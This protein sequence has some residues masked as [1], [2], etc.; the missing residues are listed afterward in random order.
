MMA[1]SASSAADKGITRTNGT[2]GHMK[3]ASR[4]MNERS[5]KDVSPHKASQDVEGLKGYQLGAC[6]GKGAFASVYKALNWGTGST[7]AI[8]QVKAENLPKTELKVI[9]M[10]IDLLKKLNVRS[11]NAVVEIN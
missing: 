7:V 2:P 6:L 1:G 5:G 10:E 11:L 9:M 8:K 3:S 4:P